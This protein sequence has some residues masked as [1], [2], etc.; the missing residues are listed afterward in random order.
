VQTT[1][2][3]PLNSSQIAAAGAALGSALSDGV[4]DDV[5]PSSG[6]RFW[7]FRREALPRR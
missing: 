4:V 3:A 2:V 7:T 1:S 5:E 6:I